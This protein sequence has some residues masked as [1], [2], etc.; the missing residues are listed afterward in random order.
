MLT[1]P[2]ASVIVVNAPTTSYSPA[3]RT[4]CSAQALSL[5]LDQAIS[6]LGRR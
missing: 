3:R 1:R 4:S 5:P 6:A 2:N